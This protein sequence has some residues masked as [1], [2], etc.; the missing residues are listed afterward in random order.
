MQK[1]TTILTQSRVTAQDIFRFMVSWRDQ[2]SPEQVVIAGFPK[3]GSTWI[4]QVAFQ[5]AYHD[6][7]ET[8]DDFDEVAPEFGRRRVVLSDRVLKTHWPYFKKF[9]V[10]N[11]I[12]VVRNPRDVFSSYFDYLVNVQKLQFDTF[13]DFFWSRFG[14]VDYVKNLDSWGSASNVTILNYEDCLQNKR[15]LVK[16]IAASLGCNFSDEEVEHVIA[17]TSRELMAARFNRQ[18]FEYDFTNVK[19]GRRYS[20]T[21]ND[22]ALVDEFCAPKFGEIQDMKLSLKQ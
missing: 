6:L 11:N 17:V 21:V 13:A 16:F 9:R 14:V 19:G 8:I 3:S 4:R 12:Y 15:G 1:N 18:G 22:K 5:I 7:P 10:L 2:L 20:L